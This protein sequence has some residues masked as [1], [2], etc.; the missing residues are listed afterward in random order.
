MLSAEIRFRSLIVATVVLIGGVTLAATFNGTVEE[1]LPGDN[2]ITI[3]LNGKQGTVK[4]FN[5]STTTQVLVDGKK[6]ELADAEA[7]QSVT[8]VADGSDNATRLTLKSVKGSG[9]SG[10]KRADAG[11]WPQHRGPHRDNI[12]TEKGLLDK[13]PDAGP[14]PGW[15]QT[16]LGEGFSSV[17]ISDGK[18]FTMGTNGKTEVLLAMNA[19][20]GKAMWSVNVGNV[21]NDGMGNGPRGTPTVDKD[22][23]YTLGANGDLVCAKV[24]KGTVVWQKNILKEYDGG[25]IT[26][27]ISESVLIDGDNLICSPGGK[28][29]TIVALNKLTGKNVWS[30]QIDG[31]PQAAYSSPIIIE[32]GGEKQYVTYVHTGVVGVRAKDGKQLWKQPESANGTAN[33]S[34]PLYADGMVFTASG[35][36]TGGA[37]FELG[38]DGVGKL[39]YANKDMVNHHGGMV[40]L[41][42]HIYGFDEQIMKCIELK[43]G[44]TNWQNRSVGK[45]SITYA[46]GHLYLR[47]ENG[48]VA[49]CVASPEGYDETGRFDPP[50]RSSKPAWSHPVVCGGKLYLRD[51]DTLLV[52]DLKK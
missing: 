28:G 12:S 49:L 14:K 13:W 5:V 46:D 18:V 41:D 43:T 24:D 4:K 32:H 33:C 47:S 27:G 35:Y 21:R 42:G 19:A 9:A 38:S 34:T 16:G 6:S 22:R 44:K 37:M 39:A 11:D 50:N 17:S 7:G 10:A 26:W 45:G 20:N 29:G 30:S 3:K 48:P 25:N 40:L 15:K 36:G 1:V 52:Y 51:Q 23:V 2:A 31:S 8:V